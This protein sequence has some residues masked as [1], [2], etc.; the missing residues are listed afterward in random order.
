MS[1][2]G[3]SYR[4]NPPEL[5]GTP[6]MS[7]L[8]HLEEANILHN[9]SIRFQKQTVYTNIA[10]VLVSIN[11]YDFSLNMYTNEML[12]KYDKNS[13]QTVPDPDIAPHCYSTAA[14][15]YKSMTQFSQS[16]S[17]IVCGESGSGKTEAAKALMTFLAKTKSP[18]GGDAHNVCEAIMAVNPILEAF[19]NAKTMMNNNSSRFGKFT[20][21]L[22][23]DFDKK[24]PKTTGRVVGALLESYLLEKSRVV[25]QEVGERNFHVF[26][27]MFAGL[28][29]E[30][31]LNLTKITDFRY[32]TQTPDHSKFHKLKGHS[33]LEE[34]KE[35][36]QAL[37]QIGVKDI[38]KMNLFKLV[39]GVLHMGN[40]EFD[41][42][43]DSGSVVNGQSEHH[44]KSVAS[45]LQVDTQD[46]RCRLVERKIKVMR[47]MITSPLSV[48]QARRNCDGMAK[49]LYGELFLWLIRKCN[50]ALFANRSAEEK[51]HQRFVGVLDVFGFE[52]FQRNSFE[53]F[54]INFAN[55][56]LQ[57][58]FSDS[59]ME[60][61]QREYIAEGIYWK[62]L[63]IP[64]ND[65]VMDLFVVKPN[66]IFSLLEAACDMPEGTVDIFLSSVFSKHSHNKRLQKVKLTKKLKATLKPRERFRGF[67][68]VHFAADVV[69][70]CSEFLSK[71]KDLASQ[72]TSALYSRSKMKILQEMFRPGNGE[73]HQMKTRN[74]GYVFTAQ[75]NNLVVT[76]TTTKSMFVRCVNPNKNK[77]ATEFDMDHVALQLRS[78]GL[79]EALK[80]M[81]LGYPTRISYKALEEQYRENIVDHPLLEDLGTNDY[82]RAILA[83]F[84]FDSSKYQFG[85]TK[86]FFKPNIPFIQCLKKHEGPLTDEMVKRIEKY[87]IEKNLIKIRGK[88]RSF[89]RIAAVVRTSR[90]RKILSIPCFTQFSFGC[91]VNLTK[92]KLREET[93]RTRREDAYH[94]QVRLLQQEE[95]A[96]VTLVADQEAKQRRL[97]VEKLNEKQ[98]ELEK[99]REKNLEEHQAQLKEIIDREN[100]M[101]EECKAHLDQIE[102]DRRKKMEETE[103]HCQK[104][105]EA[106]MS[107]LKKMKETFDESIKSEK[108]RK[109]NEVKQLELKIDELNRKVKS[110]ENDIRTRTE[111]A[112]LTATKSRQVLAEDCEKA[113]R[114]L[115]ME[116]ENRRQMAEDRL[117]HEEEERRSIWEKEK[118]ER[119]KQEQDFQKLQKRKNLELDE[120][121][122]NRVTEIKEQVKRELENEKEKRRE[123]KRVF[124]EHLRVQ[125][126]EQNQKFLQSQSELDKTRMRHEELRNQIVQ[127][128]KEHQMRLRD[129]EE[130]SRAS[131]DANREVALKE[132]SEELPK[133][134][135]EQQAKRQE[136][137]SMN[138]KCESL[139][140]SYRKQKEQQV[141]EITEHSKELLSM[142][143]ESKYAINTAKEFATE[144]LSRE[145]EKLRKI[146]REKL[147]DEI[148]QKKKE[149]ETDLK[150][151]TEKRQELVEFVRGLEEDL[152]VLQN[153]CSQKRE[154]E[155]VE[156]H[157]HTIHLRKVEEESKNALGKNR[158]MEKAKL[159]EELKLIRKTRLEELE[160]DAQKQK[161]A[162]Q[163]AIKE[164][165][166]IIQQQQ[167]EIDGYEEE[168]RQ[169][170][171]QFNN[172][173]LEHLEL[174][175]AMAEKNQQQI[176]DFLD[177][178]NADIQRSMNE[179]EE[180]RNKNAEMTRRQRDEMNQEEQKSLQ[181]IHSQMEL[182]RNEKD[183]AIK[184]DE[185]SRADIE[186]RKRSIKKQSINLER[187]R[188]VYREN[189]IL[190][191]KEKS[192]MAEQHVQMHGY[193][194][195]CFALIQAK[196]HK[197]M[198]LDEVKICL[199]EKDISL[200]AIKVPNPSDQVHRRRKAEKALKDR[201]KLLRVDA[202][203]LARKCTNKDPTFDDWNSALY[204]QSE[205]GERLSSAD[206]DQFRTSVESLEKIVVKCIQTSDDAIFAMS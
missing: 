64:N 197:F 204:L 27:Q 195:R 160:K 187:R 74:I 122:E 65:D 29:T 114:E 93:D 156:I 42:S 158:E 50:A 44:L 15:A 86:I 22:F 34:F 179:L 205:A 107:K 73:N 176:S 47:E 25:M 102:K 198:E 7:A 115:E 203:N 142:S 62:P 96:R 10:Q 175:R 162:M 191:Q 67:L 20:K 95:E 2:F 184:E 58:I 31:D 6:D 116:L 79:V 157:Q 56:R 17:L 36:N 163:T 26:F 177:L 111:A 188:R 169:R 66:G 108:E 110:L 84:G 145:I 186:R 151:I 14:C 24:S 18:S 123:R 134:L 200:P 172:E 166:L 88:L 112:A 193:I 23:S 5:D 78:G 141:R 159:E 147:D 154:Q 168:S 119:Q 173:S 127:I 98:F 52:C 164:N 194:Q 103:K 126:E 12:N 140:L 129:A 55:E 101:Q 104:Q 69:Y 94:E 199:E 40:I 189:F 174:A 132:I 60:S 152:L 59:L 161:N 97:E 53:Q 89:L 71:N 68:I 77:S 206:P 99:R 85:F 37:D 150:K 38:D 9:L 185:R 148:Q 83:G 105:K 35:L 131:I 72:E 75:L 138:E 76:L 106:E 16:Q 144:S 43:N 135:L 146:A 183:L 61:E 4:A 39:A 167:Q 120:Y 192:Q 8:V 182:L 13:L 81:K 45:L 130:K 41:A 70:N 82:W 51:T 170:I 181:N 28:S 33:D 49:S 143:E 178:K 153:Q 128:E 100:R 30:S 57:Q 137:R 155:A 80:V 90:L 117:R 91:A 180:T 124:K 171:E 190:F 109:L 202:A 32:L 121:C 113:T 133:L 201:I 125:T 3:G 87:F 118:A 19:G 54:C 136:I 165:E 21:I 63:E 48:S 46:L 92:A 149:K 11:P 139:E 1:R 196:E